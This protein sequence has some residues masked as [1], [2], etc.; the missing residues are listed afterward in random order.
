MVSG[1]GASFLTQR[2]SRRHNSQKEVG[3]KIDTQHLDVKGKCLRS[4]E[5]QQNGVFS[6]SVPPMQNDSW[7]SRI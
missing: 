2:N 7:E 4:A 6:H 3:T 1:G 5:A